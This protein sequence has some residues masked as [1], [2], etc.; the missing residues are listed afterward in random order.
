MYRSY[1]LA[2]SSA[3]LILMFASPALPQSGSG[4]AD[5]LLIL[6]EVSP[7]PS[8]GE[9]WVELLNPTDG[10]IALDGWTIG[11][12][13][14]FTYTFPP[15]S[16][17]VAAGGVHVLRITGGNPLDP[18]GDGCILS[19]PEGP[20]DAI[21]WG[22]PPMEAD[23]PLS[24]GAP[25][26]PVRG[27]IREDEELHQPDDVCMRLPG[28]WPPAVEQWVGSDNW[29]YRDAGAASPGEPNPPPPPT[30]FSPEDGADLASDF[31]L[32]VTGFEWTRQVTFQIATDPEFQDIVL[33]ETVEGYSL[34]LEDFPPGTYY[35]RVRGYT[36]EPGPWSEY[37]E[38]TR[39]P[40]DIDELIEEFEA[41]QQTGD[42]TSQ[43]D[44]LLAACK[45]GGGQRPRI[46]MRH[47]IP[48]P[49]L[50]QTKD[51][52]ML[53]LDG[54]RMD[55]PCLW[56]GA[57]PYA[58]DCK[59]GDDSCVRACIAMAAAGAGCSLSQDRITYYLF[60]EA[61]A[62]SHCATS[63]GHIGD[64]FGDIGHNQ[65]TYN[66]DITLV[67]A[68]LYN[69][70]KSASRDV[71]YHANIFDD[72]DASD[73]DSIREFVSDNRT[74]ILCS[75]Q[76]ATLITGCAVALDPDG[77]EIYA[78]KV[79][80]PDNTN[81]VNWFLLNKPPTEYRYFTFPPTTGVPQ[82]N[83]ELEMYL[84]ADHDG[85]LDFDEVRR[86]HTDPN[87]PDSDLDGVRDMQDIVGYVF[88]PDGSYRRLNPDIDGDA[89]WKHLDPDN[90]W[91]DDNGML[92][93]CED[94]NFN[95]FYDEGWDETNCFAA[96][97]DFTKFHPE[98]Q[99]GFIKNEYIYDITG[100]AGPETTGRFNWWEVISIE[101]E[102]FDSDEYVHKHVWRYVLGVYSEGG[103]VESSDGG[104]GV[105][106]ARLECDPATG[107]YLLH[108]GTRPSETN[109]EYTHVFPPAG[110]IYQWML[111]QFF[112][113]AVSTPHP[114]GTPE[115]NE[116]GALVLKGQW[117]PFLETPETAVAYPYCKQ[118]I[119][120]EIWIEPPS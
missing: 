1:L 38:F 90:D 114:L 44:R 61:G 58:Q 71:D 109:L 3:T 85:L 52:S 46:V 92:D 108:T 12:L 55:G 72:K 22:S 96:G 57:Q 56:C 87:N 47:E 8:D 23:V 54:C 49:H 70:P 31:S 4:Q 91:A 42:L 73:M 107:E 103:Y 11:F 88:K 106:K 64:P 97:D 62:A 66:A 117:E 26:M 41:E 16:G 94:P 104:T 48:C 101:D 69:Q 67:F 34:F 100:L 77:N 74:V 43:G 37:R 45:G 76:H 111:P 24:A 95:G 68:W 84:D 118:I 89:A 51:T 20:V 19:G 33:E 102:P 116:E 10:E 82:R 83:D 7:W 5:G 28:T 98:C 36:D 113:F 50:L 32:Y 25:L 27:I 112:Y 78:I 120:W 21:M 60:E 79:H 65:P 80:N 14:G 53:C 17:S 9:V 119:T 30:R 75:N 110:L 81:G 93:G 35:W 13:S 99:R 59:H 39:E 40:F 6:N 18:V 86:F 105:A 29:A 2:L 15:D 115:R 63:V